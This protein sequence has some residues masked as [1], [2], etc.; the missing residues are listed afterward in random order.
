MYK[1]EDSCCLVTG[2]AGFIGS[3]LVEILL[4]KNCKVIVLDDLTIGTKSNLNLKNS[5]L[6]F[7]E[8]SI[9]DMEKMEPLFKQADYVFH[10]A[11]QNVR[12][13]LKRPTIV[14]E[15]NSTGAL[16]VLKLATKHK[17]KKFLYCSSSEVNGTAIEVPMKEL[18]HYRPETIY[19]AS[20]LV[21]E[22]YTTVFHKSGWV[23]T[24]TVRPHNNYGPREHHEGI[25][26]EVIPRFII[27][28]Y[29]DKEITVYGDGAQTRDFTFVRDTAN[30]IVKV[31]ESE[32][33][34]GEIYNVC[35]NK[36]VSIKELGNLILKILG[37]SSKINSLPGRPNDVLRLLGD[38]SKLKDH[39]GLFPET[40]IELGLK[41]T[42]D[43]FIENLDMKKALKEVEKD[44]YWQ[45]LTP[46]QW[47]K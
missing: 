10:M 1:I 13:S 4:R 32:K 45:D 11:T 6:E 22:Y 43:W 12:L 25:F 37:K 40:T 42:V 14:H 26:G 9:L 19:G 24:C 8:G 27:Q 33:T 29:N 7:V 15:V 47:L 18:Y 38:N 46:E 16:N 39:L 36:E 28:A 30:L 5:N 20:K 35:T 3:H 31:M 41:E 34:D 23:P 21:G 2:G 17:I 44:S